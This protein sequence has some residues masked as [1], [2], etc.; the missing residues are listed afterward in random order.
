MDTIKEQSISPDIPF[1]RKIFAEITTALDFAMNSL[2]E[3]TQ[4]LP[5]EDDPIQ[6]KLIR[7]LPGETTSNTETFSLTSVYPANRRVP[8]ELQSATFLHEWQGND[9][10]KRREMLTFNMK[11]QEFPK[12][13]KLV[14]TGEDVRGSHT[15]EE[16][17]I[18]LKTR[19]L[20]ALRDFDRKLQEAKR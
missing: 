19:M 6:I 14:V 9:G 3:P 20:E 8:E 7:S 18:A 16:A 1:A 10:M 4:F 2:D 13:K 17:I 5:N 15:N 12:K 11:E